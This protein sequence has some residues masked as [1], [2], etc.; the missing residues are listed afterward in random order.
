[1]LDANL[2]TQLQA[3]LEKAVRP[4]HITAFLDDS[5]A[6]AGLQSLLRDLKEVSDRISVTENC[7]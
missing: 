6:S 5:D 2:K 4:I 1:M 7:R 3:Y